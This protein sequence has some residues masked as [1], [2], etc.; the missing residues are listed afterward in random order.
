MLNLAG[1]KIS[2]GPCGSV[3]LIRVRGLGFHSVTTRLAAYIRVVMTQLT[4]FG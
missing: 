1:T 4:R 3:G 2:Y